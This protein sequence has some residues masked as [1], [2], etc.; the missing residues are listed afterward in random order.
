M[1]GYVDFVVYTVP[2]MRDKLIVSSM[3][4]QAFEN[5]TIVVTNISNSVQVVRNADVVALGDF[6]SML[7]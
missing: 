4:F 5:I 1:N 2:I 6:R 3:A 7:P